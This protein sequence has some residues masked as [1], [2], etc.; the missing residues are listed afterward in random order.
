MLIVNIAGR[1]AYEMAGS[2]CYFAPKSFNMT[3]L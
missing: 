3:S 1:V 2:G